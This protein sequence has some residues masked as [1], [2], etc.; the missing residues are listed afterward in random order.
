[1][2]LVQLGYAYYLIAIKE[3]LFIQGQVTRFDA[4]T[5]APVLDFGEI[6]AVSICTMVYPTNQIFYNCQYP[7]IIYNQLNFLQNMGSANEMTRCCQ[8]YIRARRRVEKKDSIPD[9]ITRRTGI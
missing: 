9:P 7:G 5:G 1:M 3:R 4:M 6:K 8:R 2:D